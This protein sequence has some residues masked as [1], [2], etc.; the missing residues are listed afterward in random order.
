MKRTWRGTLKPAIS[1]RQKSI[2]SCAGTSVPAWRSMKAAGTSPRRA[3][4]MPTTCASLTPGWRCRQ[5]SISAAATFSP[6]TFSMSFRR[7]WNIM[8]PAASIEPMSPVWYQPSLSIAAAV[9]TGSL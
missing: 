6:P 9:F 8:V 7:P 5:L 3:S 2:S 4:G 1:R